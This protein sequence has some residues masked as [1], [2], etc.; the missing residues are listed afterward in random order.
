MIENKKIWL[1]EW[2]K[3]SKCAH[4]NEKDCP[5]KHMCMLYH[6]SIDRRRNPYN[7]NY[8]NLKCKKVFYRSEVPHLQLC[9]E[10]DD[11]KFA[12]SHTEVNYHP[13]NYKK[14]LCQNFADTK[15]CLWGE[16]CFCA[17][18]KTE[19]DYFNSNIEQGLKMMDLL[20]RKLDLL[21]LNDYIK[22]ENDSTFSLYPNAF[23]VER[24][25]LEDNPVLNL[26]PSNLKQ[27]SELRQ[28]LNELKAQNIDLQ[29]QNGL[30]YERFLRAAADVLLSQNLAIRK[31]ENTD[32]ERS[33]FDEKKYLG[34]IKRYFCPKCASNARNCVLIPCG[35]VFCTKCVSVMQNIC[36]S[37]NG[38]YFKC[39]EIPVVN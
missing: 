10:K 3:T 38:H 18:G 7:T 1:I 21:N 31:E 36:A 16:I 26:T 39:Q 4:D 24:L 9:H 20:I 2:Y 11:C 5:D 29:S 34:L 19:Q 6:N 8:L 35:H 13:K 15:S 14:S 27:M 23:R 37:C 12:H 32:E 28:K 17:H 33:S 30:L 22:L 25:R